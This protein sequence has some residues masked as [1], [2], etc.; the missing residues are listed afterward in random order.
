MT[1]LRAI[2][3]RALVHV[4]SYTIKLK[5]RAREEKLCDISVN[6]NAYHMKTASTP[7]VV[8]KRNVTFLEKMPSSIEPPEE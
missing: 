2:G 3:E 8:E 6:S 7:T 4:R 1:A 5:D